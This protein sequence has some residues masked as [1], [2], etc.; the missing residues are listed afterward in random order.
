MSRLK[1]SQAK[2][3]ERIVKDDL[4]SKYHLERERERDI[5]QVIEELKQ[6]VIALSKQ[7]ERYTHRIKQ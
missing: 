1:E 4:I 6:K 3:L 7:I 5:K 2:R